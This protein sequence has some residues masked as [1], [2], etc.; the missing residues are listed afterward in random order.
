MS[1]NFYTILLGAGA[2]VDAGLPTSVQLFKDYYENCS[3]SDKR[4]LNEIK[5]QYEKEYGSDKPDIEFAAEY[6]KKHHD[7]LYGLIKEYVIN[8]LLKHDDSSYL[9]TL[10]TLELDQM[11]GL[12]IG[13]KIFYKQ[14]NDPIFVPTTTSTRIF[15]LNYDRCLEDALDEKY[16]YLGLFKVDYENDQRYYYDRSSTFHERDGGFFEEWRYKDRPLAMD[17]PVNGFIKLH[18]SITWK[19]IKSNGRKILVHDKKNDDPDNMEIIFGEPEKLRIVPP[20]NHTFHAFSMAL[21]NCSALITIG[22][23]WADRHLKQL[24]ENEINDRNISIVDVSPYPHDE[25]KEYTFMPEKAIYV[26]SKAKQALTGQDV[27][28]MVG[29]KNSWD[30][31][32]GGLVG[33]VQNYLQGQIW[34][35]EKD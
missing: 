23:S 25:Y 4:I 9:K 28:V 31:V 12:K 3:E 15:S 11:Q 5:Q 17:P 32:K 21:T 2:S 6:V 1:S 33:V 20:Y 22:F 29:R 13:D 30:K 19:Y 14:A 34:H 24:I 35:S 8:R 27:E 18:G 7:K 26:R 16:P 10:F